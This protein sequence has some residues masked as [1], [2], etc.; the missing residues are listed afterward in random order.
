MKARKIELKTLDAKAH[1]TEMGQVISYRELIQTILTTSGQQGITS[2]DV[3]KAVEIQQ[4]LKAS[5]EALHLSE[6]DFAWLLTR[7]NS[8]VRWTFASEQLAEFIRD[9]HGAVFFDVP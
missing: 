8:T 3:L 9:I 6:Q 4:E 2:D 7:L 1:G 5:V